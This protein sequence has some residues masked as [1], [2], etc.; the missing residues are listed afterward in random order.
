MEIHKKIEKYLLESITDE[1]EEEEQPLDMKGIEEIYDHPAWNM[2]QFDLIGSN[3]P[4]YSDIAKKYKVDN[5]QAAT[6]ID[7]CYQSVND[8]MNEDIKEIFDHNTEHTPKLEWRGNW[9]YDTK[10]WLEEFTNDDI[11]RYRQIVKELEN[12]R[13]GFDSEEFVYDMI[14]GNEWLER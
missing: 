6:V 3:W 7:F 12:L 11:K 10:W 1:P 2:R 13:K 8:M 9:V 14:D 4:S 5:K